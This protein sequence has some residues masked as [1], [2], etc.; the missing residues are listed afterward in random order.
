MIDIAGA[1]AVES[2][3]ES[4]R[5]QPEPA[6]VAAGVRPVAAHYGDP[7]REQRLLDTEVGLVDR[8]HRGVIAV[9]G[10]DRISWLHTLT[11]QHLAELGPWQGT[12]LLVLSP[13]GHIEQHAMVAEDGDTTW[14]DTEPGATEGLLTYLEKMRF[15]SRVEPRDVTADQALLSLVGP[16]VAE[17]LALLDVPTLNAPDVSGVPGPK[18]RSG[19]VPPRPTARYD[20]KPL[21]SGGWARRGPLGVDLLVP[22]TAMDQVVT[23]LRDGG[24]GVAGLWA[25]EAVRVAARRARVGVDTDHRTIAAEVDLIAPA[26]HLDKGCYRGQETVARVHNMGR[27]PR[28]LV[29]LHLDGV[30]TD[31]LPV[32][33]TPVDFAGRTVGFVGTAVHHHELGQ[34]ALAVIKRSV[35]DDAVLRVG[36]S[37]AAIDRE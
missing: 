12:E 26:V 35:P 27:P 1:V 6:H 14:L 15:F 11:T 28:R 36:E 19:E 10:A 2:I 31:Q 9:P 32:A 21:P 30:T 37:A 20:V 17:A 18:F 23:R 13:N 24:V 4:S 8:S 16:R 3:D 33:G 29:L 5:D 34:V 22:R 25:Y 7:M